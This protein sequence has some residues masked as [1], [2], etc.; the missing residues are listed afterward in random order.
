E[1]A[2]APGPASPADNATTGPAERASPPRPSG[3]APPAGFAPPSPESSAGGAAPPPRR[4]TLDTLRDLVEEP[5]P[6]RFQAPVLREPTT[7]IGRLAMAALGWPPLG[8][9]VAAA[10][11]GSTGCGRYAA[12]CSEISSPGTWIVN[13]VLILLLLALP[14]LAAWSAHGTIIA[15]VAAVPAAIALSAG[16]GSNVPEASGPVLIAVLALAYLAGV[17]YAIVRH[18]QLGLGRSA[19]E[20]RVP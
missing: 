20:R 8:I 1:D 3:D 11:D 15:V 9:I 16:G 4:P 19:T 5:P 18:V 17:A 6:G 10:V 14:R 12:S 2:A 13:A 7:P